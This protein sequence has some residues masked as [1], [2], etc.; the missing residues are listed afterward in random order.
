MTPLKQSECFSQNIDREIIY[1][2]MVAPP[3]IELGSKV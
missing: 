1:S 3:R 2:C